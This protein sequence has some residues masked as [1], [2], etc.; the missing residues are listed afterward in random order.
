MSNTE[1]NST[2]VQPLD[3]QALRAQY[4]R[5]NH[6]LHS[7]H[8]N[9]QFVKVLRTIGF[10]KSYV[11]GLGAYLWDAD[12]TKYL[13]LNSGFGVYTMGRNHP[14]IRETLTNFL[15][16]EAASLVK[17]DAPLLSGLLAAELKKRMPNTLDTVYFG[18]SGTEGIETAIK[19]AHCATGRPAIVHC[20]KAYHGLT[21]GAL[22]LIG[23]PV[24][25]KGFG[26][27]LPDT[28]EIPFNDLAALEQALSARDVAAFIVEPVQGKGV[29]VPSPGYLS[30]AAALCRKYGTLFVADEVQTGLGRTG[31]F[32]GI[33]YDKDVDPDIVVLSK[34]LSGGYVPICAV[35]TRRRIYDKVF[36]TMERAVIHST[37]F[38]QG[39]LAM[40]AGLAALHVTDQEKLVERAEKI[41]NQLG[42]G[43]NAM[44]PKYEFL[45]EIRWRGCMVG[46]EFGPP[47]SLGLKAAW[48]LAHG[49]DK[50]L[51]PQAA[52]LP[53]M[54]DHKILTQVGGHHIDV[55]K[56]LPSLVTSDADV[57]WFLTA[58][59]KVLIDMHKFPGP[60]WEALSRIGKNA[61]LTRD[62]E[63]TEVGESQAA[64]T[65]AGTE[66]SVRTANP[67]PNESA[68]I[69]S[70]E[71]EKASETTTRPT[72]P[73][74]TYLHVL[75]RWLIQPFVTVSFVTPNGVT[76]ARLITGLIAAGLFAVGTPIWTL[77]ATV[78]FLFS[79]VLDRADGELARLRRTTSSGGHQYDTLCDMAATVL[80]FIGI[81]IGQRLGPLSGSS[82]WLGLIGGLS[83]GFIF[84]MVHRIESAPDGRATAFAGKGRW[85]PDDGLLLIAPLAW[86]NLLP[87]LLV[88]AAVGAP[89]F[90]LWT[91]YRERR[92]LMS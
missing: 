39:S 85:D 67:T 31:R 55:I 17:L 90:A 15:Q 69:E 53:L 87:W 2:S 57:R 1:T 41:G 14:A 19:Y 37:T 13:D 88:A 18:N 76:T 9:P 62:N 25:R 65:A 22:S 47:Q 27:F 7:E 33:E 82:I 72:P 29:Y 4:A 89:V 28:R 43:L 26:P 11:R 36:S 80:T 6:E 52:I 3:I 66:Q 78:I 51:F 79:A 24:F 48:K 92:L 86:F 56:L 10:D 75:G 68:S 32:L 50:S 30:E 34:A 46:I 58:F 61:L 35:L 16:E 60:V 74:R 70:D 5:R 83:I 71:P 42:E 38:G 21:M 54:E 64:Q 63:K 44:V 77:W 73:P 20:K 45:K 84:W 49:M 91:A 12:G 23:D 8:V 59:E 81:G 40:V